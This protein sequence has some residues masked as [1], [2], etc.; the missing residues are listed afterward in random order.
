MSFLVN[1]QYLL[2]CYLLW[3]YF[4]WHLFGGFSFILH[5]PN[6]FSN[7]Q[8]LFL[9]IKYPFH[10]MV[11]SKNFQCIVVY[12]DFSHC[13]LFLLIFLLPL[14]KI[15]CIYFLIFFVVSL[16]SVFKSGPVLW[17]FCLVRP[18]HLAVSCLKLLYWPGFWWI[19]LCV[20]FFS[21]GFVWSV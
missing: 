7:S 10:S 15:F 8:S 12:I 1:F 3:F 6:R 21:Y 2:S 11:A 13:N 4:E 18:S 5:T 14:H 17:P 19:L 9:C 20:Q 16:S